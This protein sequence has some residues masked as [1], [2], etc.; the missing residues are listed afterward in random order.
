MLSVAHIPVHLGALHGGDIHGIVARLWLS[1]DCN[2]VSLNFPRDS[3]ITNRILGVRPFSPSST[4][5]SKSHGDTPAPSLRRHLRRHLRPRCSRLLHRS[6]RL[7]VVL[8][9]G[10]GRSASLERS[11]LLPLSITMQLATGHRRFCQVP[12]GSKLT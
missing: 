9:E 12:A 8:C 3:T 1:V 5:S 10:T 7:L 2:L 11:S 4:A 6:R